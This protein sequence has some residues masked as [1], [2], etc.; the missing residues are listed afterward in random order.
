[1]DPIII[2]FVFAAI[3]ALAGI[4]TYC[5]RCA[6]SGIARIQSSVFAAAIASSSVPTV[7]SICCS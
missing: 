5:S 6:R 2:P 3:L 1:M 4:V 7:P